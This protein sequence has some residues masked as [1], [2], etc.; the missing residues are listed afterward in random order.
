M[1]TE[2]YEAFATEIPLMISGE[3][4][5]APPQSSWSVVSPSLVKMG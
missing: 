2:V 5:P 3:Q 4:F 1:H